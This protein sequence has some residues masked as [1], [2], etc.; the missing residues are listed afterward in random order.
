MTLRLRIELNKGGLGISMDKLA[1]ITEETA[2]F[3]RMIIEDV[4]RGIVGAWVAKDFENNSVDFTAEYIGGINPEQIQACK[5]VLAYTMNKDLDVITLDTR[6]RRATLL[7]Y[8]KIAKP[9]DPDE[10]VYFGLFEN[11]ESKPEKW[12]VL[13]KERSLDI[14]QRLQLSDRIEYQG[15]IQGVITALFKENQPH[16]RVRELYSDLL[17]T[18]FFSY[19]LYDKIIYALQKKDM[20]VHIAGRVTASRTGRK[21]LEMYI[22]RI[23]VAEEYQKGDLDKFIGCAPYA[24]GNLSTEQFIDLVRGN[25]EVVTG[26]EEIA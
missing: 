10:A 5:Q 11:R 20:V 23:E 9:I 14:E 13:S 16:C 12:Y 21:P 19:E 8:A 18:C 25:E 24:T 6:I 17:I 3:L 15:S 26:S 4:D 2:Q 22:K 7:Q 1:R